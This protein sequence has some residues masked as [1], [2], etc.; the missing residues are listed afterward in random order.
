MCASSILV[1]VMCMC[2]RIQSWM[3]HDVLHC[4]MVHVHLS[5]CC[6]CISQC[7]TAASLSARVSRPTTVHWCRMLSAACC[8]AMQPHVVGVL[9]V[10]LC[11]SRWMSQ[12]PSATSWLLLCAGAGRTCWRILRACASK[13]MAR[14]PVPGARVGQLAP[15]RVRWSFS[16][17]L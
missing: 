12:S 11:Q 15:A 17:V 10:H 9:A 5:C 14:Q 6:C 3:L 4:A 8:L 13:S 16:T 2:G 1:L 7:R